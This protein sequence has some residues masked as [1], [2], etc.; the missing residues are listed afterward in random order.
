MA[1]L[2]RIVYIAGGTSGNVATRDLLVFD[3]HTH[4]VT[5]AS[6]LPHGVTHAAAAAFGCCVYVIGGRGIQPGTPTRRIF[7]FDPAHRHLQAAGPAARA[8]V[9]PRR[10][11]PAGPHPG[12]RRPRRHGHRVHRRRAA[13]AGVR[14]ALAL[15]LLAALALVAAGCGED[16]DDHPAAKD[17]VFKPPRVA[18]HALP[19][20]PPVLNPLDV[21]AADRPGRLS[22]GG[23]QGPAA[24]LRAEQQEQHGRRDRPAHL[25]DRRATSPPARC[26][27]T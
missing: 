17:P 16:S 25:Q 5:K 21:Y 11:D 7:A 15:L 6:R 13:A 2:G 12:V 19:G 22:R 23:A 9:G 4:A 8:A 14:R 27:S 18:G 26:R 20:M 24:H 1:A 10:R 3:T